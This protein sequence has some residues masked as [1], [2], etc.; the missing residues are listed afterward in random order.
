MSI[1][2]V[3]ECVSV[4]KLNSSKIVSSGGHENGGCVVAGIEVVCETVVIVAVTVWTVDG[5]EK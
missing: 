3:C 5:M 4:C 1:L 2:L